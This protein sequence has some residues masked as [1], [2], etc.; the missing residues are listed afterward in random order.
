MD[1]L[2]AFLGGLSCKIYDDLYDNGMIGSHVQEVLKGSQWILLTLLSYNDFNFSILAY[3]ANGLNALNNWEE[4]KHPYETSLLL[5]YPFLIC[6]SFWS[7]A[8]LNVYD[9]LVIVYILM[10]LLYHCHNYFYQKNFF[11]YF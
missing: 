5:L 6:I 2:Y 8:Y 1:Y 7:R 9:I 3:I 10:T 11:Y 4:W